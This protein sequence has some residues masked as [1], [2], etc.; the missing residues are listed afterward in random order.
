MSILRLLVVLVK[1]CL[2][3]GA[4]FLDGFL[5]GVEHLLDVPFAHVTEA[6]RRLDEAIK[7]QRDAIAV[8]F[9]AIGLERRRGSMHILVGLV[10]VFEYADTVAVQDLLALEQKRVDYV[11]HIVKGQIFEDPPLPVVDY[12]EA[13]VRIARLLVQ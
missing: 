2:C 12:F 4:Q 11:E 1:A 10:K 9:D 3:L 7:G 8:V 13:D 5:F 6:E